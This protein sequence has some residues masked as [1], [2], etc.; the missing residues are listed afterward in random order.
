MPEDSPEGADVRPGSELPRDVASGSPG[1]RTSGQWLPP[2]P[3]AMQE[4]LP[5]FRI[6]ELLGCAGMGA[7]YKGW[8]PSLERYVAVKIL[9]PAV[10][11][12][13]AQFAARFKQEAKTMARFQHPGIVSIYDAGE[14]AG[15]LLY[16]VME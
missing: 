9:P 10:V 8:Q 7:V 4:Q 1:S 6:L 14:T 13:D 11:E 5:H 15:G 2:A 16:I 3:E 12:G